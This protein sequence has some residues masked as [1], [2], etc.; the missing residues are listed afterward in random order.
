MDEASSEIARGSGVLCGAEVEPEHDNEIT[1]T[2]KNADDV[3]V[4]FVDRNLN[5]VIFPISR[6]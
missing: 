3:I 5:R 2:I 1:K 6:K 4:L